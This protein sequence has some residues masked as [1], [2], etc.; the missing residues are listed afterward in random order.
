MPASLRL[1][2]DESLGK[3]KYHWGI[4]Y[5]PVNGGGR[6]SRRLV[7]RGRGAGP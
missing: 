4:R 6:G 3:M 5:P 1:M 2:K 7:F